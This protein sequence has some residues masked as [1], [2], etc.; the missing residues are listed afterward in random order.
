MSKLKDIDLD[1][2]R[3][4][5]LGHE[6]EAIDYNSKFDG[7]KGYDSKTR[8]KER[9]SV[10][11]KAIRIIKKLQA[12]DIDPFTLDYSFKDENGIEWELDYAIQFI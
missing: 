4:I 12:Q 9:K 3:L 5:E 8:S 11:A 1:I 6:L 10:R 2:R 7:Y